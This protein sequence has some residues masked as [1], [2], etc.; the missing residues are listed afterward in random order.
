[1]LD[2]D[3]ESLGAVLVQWIQHQASAHYFILVRVSPSSPPEFL[4][5]DASSDYRTRG[6]S[7]YRGEEIL[8]QRRLHNGFWVPQPRHE[9]GYYLVKKVTKGVLTEAHSRRLSEL[10]GEDPSGCAREIDRFW[11]PGS[12]E[13]L[14]TA[15]RSGDW[16]PVDA[17]L[18]ALRRD[19]LRSTSVEKVRRAVEYWARDLVRRVRR[20]AQ[21]SGLHVVM[22]GPDG[23]GKSTVAALVGQ[24]LSSAFRRVSTRHLRPGLFKPVLAGPP[25]PPDAPHSRPARNLAASVAKCLFW[26]LDYTV[27]YQ[28]LVRPAL[29][30]STLVLFDRYLLYVL[31]DPRRYRYGGPAWLIQALWWLA[32]KPDLVILLDAPAEV[33][34]ARKRDLPLEE[35]ERQRAAYRELVGNLANGHVVDAAQS[36]GQVAAQVEGIVLEFLRCRTARRLGLTFGEWKAR[37]PSTGSADTVPNEVPAL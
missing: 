37:A 13:L 31:V 12:A 20:W 35:T 30:R 7:F 25:T 36:V 22:L 24:R 16:R 17:R 27:G 2:A 3:R 18:L 34:Q 29:V 9:F 26:L 21:P 4:A 10:Y 6:T 33:L 28:A 19:L 1:M 15:A 23:A 32:P 14:T 5:F 8:N 11:P